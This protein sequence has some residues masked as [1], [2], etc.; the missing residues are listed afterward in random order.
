MRVVSGLERE[1]E[2]IGRSD[3]GKQHS[4]ILNASGSKL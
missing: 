2:R 3:A 1:N 4:N